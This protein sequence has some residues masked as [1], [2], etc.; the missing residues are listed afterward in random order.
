[1]PPK[2]AASAHVPSKQPCQACRTKPALTAWRLRLTRLGGAFAAPNLHGRSRVRRSSTAWVHIRRPIEILGG[3]Q[4]AQFSQRPAKQSWIRPLG[5]AHAQHVASRLPARPTSPAF[6]AG[7]GAADRLRLCAGVTGGGSSDS[8]EYF[9]RARVRTASTSAGSK[10]RRRK[11]PVQLP[12]DRRGPSARSV[13]ARRSSMP[14]CSARPGSS[15]ACSRPLQNQAAV[16]QNGPPAAAL[17][18]AANLCLA[19]NTSPAARR[20]KQ[21]NGSSARRRLPPWPVTAREADR[22]HPQRVKHFDQRLVNRRVK[23]GRIVGQGMGAC[24]IA[25]L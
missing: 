19:S 13:A 20:L 23:P 18:T 5:T 15:G 8:A 21:R 3:G 25:R 1:M 6:L 17:R 24:G 10:A 16:L 11:A 22:L 9:S 7:D 12:A 4:A 14:A 2:R